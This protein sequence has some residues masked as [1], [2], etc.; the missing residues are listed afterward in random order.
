MSPAASTRPATPDDV[1]GI[2]R[3][4]RDVVLGSSISFEEVPPDPKEMSKRMLA[5]PR[6]PWLVA[7]VGDVVVGYAYASRHRERAGYRWSAECSVYVDAP[8]RARGIGRR[9]YEALIDEVA[10][11]GYI[12]LFAGIALPNAASTR[13]HASLGFESVGVFR[14]VGYKHGRWHDVAWLRRQLN[15]PPVSPLEPRAWDPATA[16]VEGSRHPSPE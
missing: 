1:G 16:A 14:A 5:N 6:L 7:S 9:L 10:S 4:Y 13:L 3:I 2:S 12:S 15:E 8:F 11:L